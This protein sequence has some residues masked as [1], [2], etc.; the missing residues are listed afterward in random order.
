MESKIALVKMHLCVCVSLWL[1]TVDF[2]FNVHCYDLPYFGLIGAN[3][4]RRHENNL[5]IVHLNYLIHVS[6]DY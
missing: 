4:V 5:F 1:N 6:R 2:L 3:N